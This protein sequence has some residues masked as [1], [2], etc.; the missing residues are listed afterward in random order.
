MTGEVPVTADR[1]GK[2]LTYRLSGAKLG[3]ANNGNPLPT[4]AFGPPVV[5]IALVA[6]NAGVDLV[7]DLSAEQGESVPAYR[8]ASQGGLAT[9]HVELPPAPETHTASADLA[10]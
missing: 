6:T 10:P 1:A 7:I 8:F 5:N 4:E 3:V 9:L 2:R